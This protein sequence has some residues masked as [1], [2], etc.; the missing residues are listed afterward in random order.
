L[1]IYITEKGRDTTT[2]EKHH[3]D[4]INVRITLHFK[5]IVSKMIPNHQHGRHTGATGARNEKLGATD[6]VLF[7]CLFISRRKAGTP[8]QLSNT[9]TIISM[10]VSHCILSAPSTNEDISLTILELGATDEVFSNHIS[11]R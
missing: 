1:F 3:Y 9:I 10:Y 7:I 4:Y 5:H 8:Q 2:V 6:E 11:S